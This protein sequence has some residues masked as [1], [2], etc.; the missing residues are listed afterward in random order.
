MPAWLTC[1]LT[2]ELLHSNHWRM[3]LQMLHDLSGI[4]EREWEQGG[5]SEGGGW[6]WRE[7][8]RV[9]VCEREREGGLGGRERGSSTPFKNQDFTLSHHKFGKKLKLNHIRC[10][11]PRSAART[12]PP[13]THW[14]LSLYVENTIAL[15]SL[16]FTGPLFTARFPMS[17]SRAFFFGPR[18]I[19]CCC[20]C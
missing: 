12:R 19:S 13:D 1:T 8:A 2:D 3:L 10:F 9:C 11:V 4:E 16:D 7:G 5:G 18:S 15:V 14:T 17:S 6:G 20:S